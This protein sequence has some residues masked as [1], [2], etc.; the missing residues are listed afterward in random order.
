MP[1]PKIVGEF[2]VGGD[3]ELRFL[4]SGQA[5][6]NFSVIASS[7][8]KKDNGEWETTAETGWLRVN[9]WGADAERVANDVTKGSK[10]FLVGR[11]KQRK[12]TG[13]D[14]D[15]RTAIEIDADAIG[16]IPERN[17]A[18]RASSGGAPASGSSGGGGDPWGAAPPQTDEPPF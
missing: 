3:P 14:G 11:Y 12:F 2:R 4:P 17:D 15:E 1:L 13:R 16:V 8:R 6:A 10:V 7:N 18:Q 5:A 9:V